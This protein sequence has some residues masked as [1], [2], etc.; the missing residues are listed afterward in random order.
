MSGHTE[1]IST[2]DTTGGLTVRRARLQVSAGPDADA[3]VA[4]SSEKLTIGSAPGNDLVLSDSTVSR[5]HAE[6]VRERGGYRLRDLESTN[7]TRVDHV[8]ITDA[9]VVDGS[10]LTFGNTAVR[11]SLVAEQDVV[12]LH[13]EPRFGRLVGEGAV[14]RALFARLA[15]LAVT[16]ATVLIEGE[17]G[18]G[19][20][21][22]AEALHQQSP[23]V[24]GPFVV[25]DCGSIPAELVESELFGHEKGAFTGA[26]HE[27]RGAFEAARGGTLF[28]DEIGELPLAVQPRLLRAL[29]RRQ[30]KRVGADA[31]R[32]VDVRFLAATHRDLRAA[33]NRGEF[34]EDLYF[35]LAVGMVR[36]PPLRSRLDDLPLL[37]RHLWE[38]TFRT[39]G[40][41]LRP[42]APPS[43]ET[44]RQLM[45]LPWRGNVREL[46]NFV[47]RSVA[48]S[49]ALATAFVQGSP[50]PSAEPALPS[51]RVDLPYKDAKEAWLVYFE[52]TYLRQRLR[53][54]G[55]NVSQMAREAEVDRAHVIKLLRKHAVR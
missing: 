22:V 25:V 54:A 11:F 47:E 1:V 15:R 52:E 5:F 7:G 31:F 13:P 51:V 35:R 36:V 26:T 23:R 30:V 49:G 48:M 8:R 55:G 32:S 14:M 17:S 18:T 41:S 24:S 40:L 42:Y 28:L 33:V 29:E 19:K 39:L 20:E 46:R 6:L 27:R 44:L 12:P 21:L 3:E 38:E 10:T 2:Q 9:Y 45:S 37:L 16:D 43:P 50:S 4:S 53:T 34:R